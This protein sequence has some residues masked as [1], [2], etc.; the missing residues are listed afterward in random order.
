[1]RLPGHDRRS[2]RSPPPAAP[3]GGGGAPPAPPPPP[4]SGLTPPPRPRPRARPTPPPPPPPRGGEEG[5]V[6]PG[7]SRGGDAD[8]RLWCPV[9]IRPRGLDARL[10]PARARAGN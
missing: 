8:H 3:H 9:G 4:P 10:R 7:P 5:L 1:M 6:V 2:A